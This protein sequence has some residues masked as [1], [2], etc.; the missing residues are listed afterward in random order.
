MEIHRFFFLG[1]LILEAYDRSQEQIFE[2]IENCHHRRKMPWPRTHNK[3]HAQTISAYF[4][5]FFVEEPPSI[6]NH[7]SRELILPLSYHASFLH[8]SLLLHADLLSALRDY[9]VSRLLVW[10]VRDPRTVA[11]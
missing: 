2:K 7:S 11:P 5:R 9:S 4:R 1:F 10:A 6:R 3:N 8:P